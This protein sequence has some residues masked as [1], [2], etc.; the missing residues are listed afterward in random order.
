MN[1]DD[2]AAT[3]RVPKARSTTAGSAA[4]LRVL[5]LTGGG[6]RG[7]F[8]A[9]ALV[10]LCKA[11]RRRGALHV[12][13]DVFAGTSIGG[14]MSCALAV[15]VIPHRVLDAIDAHGPRVF[16]AK[17]FATVRRTFFGTLYDGDNL[18]KAIDECL[19]GHA[20]T[21]LKD[22][23][24][25]LVVPAIDWV[26][27]RVEIYLSAY[28]GKSRAS[29]ATLKEVCLATSAA[30]TYFDPSYVNGAPMLDGGL[31][32]NNPD[33]LALMEIVRRFPAILPRVEML[34]IGTAGAEKVR[35]P[36]RAN[37]SGIGWAPDLAIFM[38]DVQER[39]AAAQSK[40]L[41]VDRYLRVNHPGAPSK[42]FQ[43]MDA[44]NDDTRKHL[45]QAGRDVAAAAYKTSGAFIERFLSADRRK[46]GSAAVTPD[47]S[48]RLR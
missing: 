3:L 12:S 7:L 32:A 25:G 29:N 17:R 10:G 35:A 24:H 40:R 14:L 22:I 9:Q 33:T 27:G 4:P 26:G 21:R 11:A 1:T 30:P 31:A 46:G 42:A 48:P 43:Q 20:S 6:Y 13:I 16:E 47:P 45:M 19:G 34:S 23:E 2:G 5:S 8:T 36:K 28:F 38:M 39:T 41:L 44:A 37:R 18:A 15:G